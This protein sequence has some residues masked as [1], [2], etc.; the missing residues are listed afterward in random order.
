[1]SQETE[2]AGLKNERITY[3]NP[4][5]ILCKM[6]YFSNFFMCSFQTKH[7]GMR[8]KK[9]STTTQMARLE[10]GVKRTSQP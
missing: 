10:L 2:R 5:L 9:K 8:A 1:M 6:I 4:R 7:Q 3:M